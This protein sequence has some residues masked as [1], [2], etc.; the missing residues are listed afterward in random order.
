MS[1]SERDA[2]SFSIA[3]L[4]PFLQRWRR[5]ILWIAIPFGTIVL[6]AFFTFYTMLW[7]P[8]ASVRSPLPD[9]SP[10]E[11]NLTE[12]LREHVEKLAGDIGERN[13]MRYDQLRAAASYIENAFREMGYE[14][15]RVEFQW[16]QKTAANIEVVLSGN[17]REGEHIVIG[18][19][20]DT[21]PNS[22][23]ADD[24]ASGV[25]GLLELAE[26]Y[27]NRSPRRTIRF[28]A[29]V[30]EEQP[31][32]F[33]ERM[34][35]LVYARHLR[36]RE[37]DVKGMISLEMLGYYEEET[38]QEYPLPGLSLWL[39]DR[40]NFL[41]FVTNLPSR[42]LLYTSIEAFR[43]EGSLPTEGA[44]LPASVRGVGF[45]DH[46]SF[47]QEGYPGLMVTDTAMFRNPHYHTTGDLPETL[48][49]ERMARAVNGMEAVVE[50]LAN[51]GR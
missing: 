18:A 43:K 49:Y 22:P 8:G 35:S 42:D 48:D 9:L 24:N 6:V 16:E 29:F 19:H 46:W 31:F 33:S 50:R 1:T 34:G 23:G 40:G 51:P 17:E 47:W 14:P 25:A 3:S 45:S 21:V 10:A 7:M 11:Q 12:P 32:A 26:H 5:T 39:P 2:P 38:V 13:L 30:N 4:I 15:N 20:Y 28:V 44:A 41:A 27:K 37:I 36:E